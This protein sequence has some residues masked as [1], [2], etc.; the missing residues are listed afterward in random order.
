MTSFSSC[1]HRLSNTAGFG[2]SRVISRS[3]GLSTDDGLGE[4]TK[5]AVD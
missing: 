5:L 3:E 2:P 1:L 4:I